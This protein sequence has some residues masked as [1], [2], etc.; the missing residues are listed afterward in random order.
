[1]ETATVWRPYG[2]GGYGELSRK[3]GKGRHE[4]ALF[5][6]G[7]YGEPSYG[8]EEPPYGYEELYHRKSS[9]YGKVRAT[10]L[11]GSNAMYNPLSTYGYGRN[12]GSYGIYG[13]YAV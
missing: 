5:G 11:I 7:G 12:F 8:Y 1:M 3:Y 4:K 10:G 6:K 13:G 9:G 2:K